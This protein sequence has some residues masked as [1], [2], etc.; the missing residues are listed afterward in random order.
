MEAKRPLRRWSVLSW[1]ALL[2]V[3][4]LAGCGG[5]S[6]PAQQTNAR[7]TTAAT[8]AGPTSTTK[9]GTAS[10]ASETVSSSSSTA[11][12]NKL[13][14][15]Y[16][17]LATFGDEASGS[18]RAAI[19]TTLKRYLDAVASGNWNVVCGLLATPVRGE[20]GQLVRSN[21]RLHGASCAT[22]LGALSGHLPPTAR[23]EQLPTDVQS[24]RVQGGRAFVLYRTKQ[25]PHVSLAVM[26][27]AGTW[28]LGSL[29]GSS[30]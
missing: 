22:I 9:G 11:K 26:R 30:M 25:A 27:E 8:T 4:A 23:R 15:F 13:S 24:V 21:K 7:A 28:R 12:T 14:R 2:A 29:G 1:V 6:H 19:V 3:G 10:T 17:D 18:E 16:G 20:L 5:S